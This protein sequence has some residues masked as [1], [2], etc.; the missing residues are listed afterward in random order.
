MS[1]TLDDL[2]GALADAADTVVAP[3]PDAT[4]DGARRHRATATRRRRSG[5]AALAL[6]PWP[7]RVVPWAP[8][9]PSTGRRRSF[10][11]SAP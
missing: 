5:V 3:S 6:A 11:P 2:R 9:G 1:A 10:P 8:G 4:V 7:P